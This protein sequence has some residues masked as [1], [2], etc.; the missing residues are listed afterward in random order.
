MKKV[1]VILFLTLTWFSSYSQSDSALVMIAFPH[2]NKYE[3]RVDHQKIFTTNQ[4]NLTTG[5]HIIEIWN[6]NFEIE[7]DTIYVSA[8]N[9]NVFRYPMTLS[10]EFNTYRKDLK[11]YKTKKWN[12]IILPAALTL[13]GLYGSFHYYRIGNKQYTELVE[14]KEEYN[15]STNSILLSEYEDTFQ[16]MNTVYNQTRKV[17]AGF[18]G[19]TSV[20]ATWAILGSI[21]F[22]K[23]YSKP[24]NTLNKSPFSN[25]EYVLNMNVLPGQLSLTFQF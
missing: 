14:L 19:I 22:A 12:H 2:D 16:E 23:K 25:K 20:V 17:Y 10:S 6:A 1:I 4:F 21:T 8:L 7:I 15:N 24:I 18:V 5:E 11:S 13:G 9:N 3:I